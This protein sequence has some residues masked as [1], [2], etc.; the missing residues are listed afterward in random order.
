[1][2][3]FNELTIKKNSDIY[4]QYNISAI[5]GVYINNNLVYIGSSIHCM[6]RFLQHKHKVLLKEENRHAYCKDCIPI[7]NAL[8][9]ALSDGKIITFDILQKEQNVKKLRRLERQYLEQYKPPLNV[10]MY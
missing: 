2:V 7:Y 10:K 9:E 5:Y 8:R 6:E 1:M 4:K 3:D